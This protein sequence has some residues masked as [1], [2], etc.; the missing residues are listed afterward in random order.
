MKKLLIS[1]I[2]TL[3]ILVVVVPTNVNAETL[4]NYIDKVNKYTSELQADKD[5]LALNEQEIANIKKE[6]ENIAKEVESINKQMISIKEEQKRLEKEIEENNIKIKEKEAETKK[7]IKNAQISNGDNFY[8]DYVFGADS[9]TDMIYRISLVEQ[10]SKYNDKII[11][12]MNALIKSNEKKK[13]ELSDKSEELKK[14]EANLKVQ[15]EKQQAEQK[16]LGR[17]NEELREGMPSIEQEIKQAQ[18]MV[19]FYK[20]KGCKPSDRIGIDCAVIPP[21]TSGGGGNISSTG[22]FHRPIGIGTITS[23]F[24]SRNLLDGFHYGLDMSN[25]LGRGNTKVY[26]IAT[27]MIYYVGTDMYGAKIVRI[28]HNYNGKIVGSTY[29]HLD[30]YAPGIY[31]GKMVG[32]DDYIGIMGNTGYSFGMHLHLEVSDCPYLYAGSSCY[33]WNSYTNYLRSNWQTPTKYIS[34]PSSWSTR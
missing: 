8:F 5:K 9:L 18:S 2:C 20:N 32:L 4:Q 11:D 29:V 10:I 28:A 7:L 21:S 1:L 24:G 33:G 15:K 3:T 30:S 26:P 6:L 12:E 14:L 22:S 16:K 17:E 27:G 19:T 13:K 25:S 31:V 23:G 34:F